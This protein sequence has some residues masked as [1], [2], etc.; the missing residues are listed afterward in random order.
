MFEEHEKEIEEERQIDP[1]SLD[2]EWLNQPNLFYKY[3]DALDTATQIRNELKTQLENLK[4]HL[5]FVRSALEL[6]IRQNPEAFELEKVTE[7]SIKAAVTIHPDYQKALTE[8]Q[9]AREEFNEAQNTVNRC[10]TRV[11]TISEKR[12]SLERLVVLLNQQYFS[13][14]SVPRDLRQEYI[15]YQKTRK[16]QREARKKVKERKRKNK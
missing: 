5:E 12:T 13:T 16:T 6:K 4:E 8:L 14:P 1:D 7:S 10:Y 11:N 15:A 3:S 2:V 9:D